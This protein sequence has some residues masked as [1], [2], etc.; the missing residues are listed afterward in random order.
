M[1]YRRFPGLNPHRFQSRGLGAMA[2]LPQSIFGNPVDC[3]AYM[4]W[5][6]TPECWKYAPSAWEQI[7]A[8]ERPPS[9]IIAPPPAV[10]AAYGS[11]AAPYDCT[12]NPAGN[13]SCPGYDAAVTAALKAGAAQ[14]S[15]NIQAWAS[16][17][18]SVPPSCDGAYQDANGDWQCPATSTTNWLLYGGI[19]LGVFA[20][21]AVSSGGPRR[22]GR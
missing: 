6:S 1:A 10:G 19:A 9:S 15:S 20:L 2:D 5:I 8:F 22:Y 13:P 18:P 14:T 11:V 16:I 12:A 17:Q 21:V 7:V 3:R 4:T